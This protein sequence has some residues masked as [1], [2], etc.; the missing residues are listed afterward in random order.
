MG[1]N[2]H[3]TGIRTRSEVTSALSVSSPMLGGQS[4]TIVLN[5]FPDW[6]SASR[7]DVFSSGGAGEFDSALARSR[8]LV[9]E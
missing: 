4:I 6:C 3:W 7:Q 5:W 2:S 9:E 8:L 1:K